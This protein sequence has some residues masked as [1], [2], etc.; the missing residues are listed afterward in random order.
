MKV[1]ETGVYTPVN[2]DFEHFY[3]DVMASAVVYQQTVKGNAPR[4]QGVKV[5]DTRSLVL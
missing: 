5:Y 2:E 1:R 4:K 3:N